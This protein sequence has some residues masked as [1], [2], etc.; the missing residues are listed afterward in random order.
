MAKN[1]QFEQNRKSAK[2]YAKTAK[3]DSRWDHELGIKVYHDYSE[4]KDKAYWDDVAFMHGSQQV[5]VWFTHPRYQWIEAVRD[6]AYNSLVKE[7]GRPPEMTFLDGATANYKTIGKNKNRKRVISWTLAPSKNSDFY[8]KLRERENEYLKTSDHVQYCSFKI[9]QYGHCR[10]VD[11]CVPF[12]VVDEQSLAK[13]ADFVKDC[14]NDTTLFEKTFG[15]YT[16]TVVDYL[17][18]NPDT[19]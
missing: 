2:Q 17:S 9:K 3:N 19:I 1:K 10:G 11:I 16:Y 5:T 6:D 7:F 13:L 14:I 15:K 8:E 12:E 4:V 18:E